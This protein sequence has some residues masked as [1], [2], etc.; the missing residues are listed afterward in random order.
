[1]QIQS[2]AE[3]RLAG[4]PD[5]AVVPGRG[6][7][8]ALLRRVPPSRRLPLATFLACQAIFLAWWVALYPGLLSYDSISFILHVT[9]GPWVND[10]SVLYDS[11]VWL[12]LHATGGLAALTLAQTIAASIALAYTA[13]AFRSL[14]VPGRWTATAAVVVAALPPTGGFILLVWKDVPFT[15]CTVLLV[16][17]LARLVSL[18]DQPGWHRDRLTHKTVAAVGLEFLGI[19]LF[20]LNGFLVVLIAVAIMI[21]VLPLIRLRL[22]AVAAAGICLTALLNLV[23]YPAAGIQRIPAVQAYATTYGDIAVAY[24]KKPQI[25]SKPDLRLLAQVAP[26]AEWAG[27]ATCSSADFT[28][29]APDIYRN[30]PAASGKLLQ[31]WLRLFARAPD[32]IIGTRLCRGAIAW[33][34]F[35]G[36]GTAATQVPVDTIPRGLFGRAS[37][38]RH[39]PYRSALHQTALS[40]GLTAAV[41]FWWKVSLTPQLDWLLWRGAVWCYLAYGIIIGFARARRRRVFLS[42]AAIVAGQQLAITA[43]N[44]AQFYRYMVSPILIGILLIP[45]FFAR[46]RGNLPRGASAWD[47]AAPAGQPDPSAAT[48]TGPGSASPVPLPVPQHPLFAANGEGGARAG[49]EPEPP[50]QMHGA[51]DQ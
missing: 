29:N 28:K 42:L 1:M 8:L 26:L 33:Q 39:N 22:A 19:M 50:R 37:Q 21:A 49:E 24:A 51:Q 16:P 11:L 34:I 10:H 30:A 14:G 20:R 38:V 31:L 32:L 48:V 41:K 12:S 40:A 17:S 43:D 18:Q 6:T 47:R 45:L 35:P 9:T 23:V 13:S 15:I 2:A 46:H 5:E 44:P 3:S 36:K 4:G 27:T 25:F 7:A